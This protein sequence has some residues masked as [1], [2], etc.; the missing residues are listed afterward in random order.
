MGDLW[1]DVMS[2][3]G[4]F[5]SAVQKCEKARDIAK[6]LSQ[7]S[8]R[9]GNCCNWM[10]RPQCPREHGLG[11]QKGGPSMNG[12]SCSHYIETEWVRN[13]KQNLQMAAKKK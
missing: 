3:A 8:P 4:A 7:C 5:S 12:L 9:C 13:R 6:A 11:S 10:K 1:A 2:I